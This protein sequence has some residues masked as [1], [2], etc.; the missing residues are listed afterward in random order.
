MC[1]APVLILL[2]PS[3]AQGGA[4]KIARAPGEARM[5]LGL[6]LVERAI[7]AARRAGYGGVLVLGGDAR[8]PAR[9]RR[10]RRL[11]RPR[12]NPRLGSSRAAAHHRPRLDPCANRLAR[13]RRFDMGSARRLGGDSEPDRHHFS[14]GG[15]GRGAGSR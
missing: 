8:T 15:A 11:A 1:E 9:A 6:S 12:R 5:I 13:T 4:A 2:A 10:R 14:R 3:T 7:L